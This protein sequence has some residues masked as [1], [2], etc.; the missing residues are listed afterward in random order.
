MANV[1]GEDGADFKLLTHLDHRY[2]HCATSQAL[3]KPGA[4]VAA[5]GPA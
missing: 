4:E 5:A 2:R 3:Q 1:A